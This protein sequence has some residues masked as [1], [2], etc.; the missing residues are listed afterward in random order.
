[1]AGPHAPRDTV[2]RADRARW[3]STSLTCARLSWRRAS[4]AR[5]MASQ[6]ASVDLPRHL[7]GNVRRA[8]LFDTPVR[9]SVVPRMATVQVLA[10]HAR[11]DVRIEARSQRSI[12]TP[13]ARTAHRER[14]ADTLLAVA[15]RATRQGLA[16]SPSSAPVD[17]PG[18]DV[19]A[20]YVSTTL[21]RVGHAKRRPSCMRL[22]AV[23]DATRVSTMRPRSTHQRELAPRSA[24]DDA[25]RV[26]TLP[27]GSTT[28]GMWAY[29]GSP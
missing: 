29:A 13:R 26:S 12:A 4:S 25:T 2:H 8:E 14:Q 24:C 9:I 27:V 21:P 15:N 11:S 19:S 28:G 23:D 22:D 3:R 7:N 18:L 1:M 17:C 10:D 6:L 20:P 5:S 16:G